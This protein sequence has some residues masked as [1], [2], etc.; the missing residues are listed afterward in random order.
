MGLLVREDWGKCELLS[1]DCEQ[2]LM[3]VRVEQSPEPLYIAVA[4]MRP[5]PKWANW[6]ER[7]RVGLTK[8]VLIRHII[9]KNKTKQN[10]T[11]VQFA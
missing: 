9:K 7:V 4:Y 3:W 10:K 2:D 1:K 5:G 6:R 11:V 8:G